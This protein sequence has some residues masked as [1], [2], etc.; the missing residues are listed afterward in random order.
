[1]IVPSPGVP[2]ATH[3]TTATFVVARSS[4]GSFQIGIRAPRFV[5]PNTAFI[6][7]SVN[8]TPTQTFPCPL[9]SVKSCTATFAVPAGKN[10]FS[11]VAQDAYG[12]ALS[13][14]AFAQDC[15]AGRNTTIRAV[16]NGVVAS[17]NL[18]VTKPYLPIGKP[19]TLKVLVAAYDASGAVIVGPGK[20]SLP[21]F[22]YDS[23]TTGATALSTKVVT[24]PS[25][26]VTLSYDGAGYVDPIITSFP[27]SVTFN[28]QPPR[29]KPLLPAVEVP[30][31]SG[32]LASN[33][34]A[35]GRDGAMW[36]SD[37]RGIGRAGATISEYPLPANQDGAG[38]VVRGSNGN[39]WFVA[40]NTQFSQG[41]PQGEVGQIDPSGKFTIYQIDAN[42][43][44]LNTVANGPDGNVWF[45]YINNSIGEIT[46]QGKVE[47]YTPTWRGLNLQAADLVTGSDG[48]LWIADGGLYLLWKYIPKTGSA[49]PYNLPY[50]FQPYRIVVGS[51]GNFYMNG[52]DGV[53]EA[54]AGGRTLTT[55]SFDSLPSYGQM[56]SAFGAIWV[57]LGLDADGHPEIGYIST[58]DGHFA[59]LALPAVAPFTN[60][61]AVPTAIALGP[62]NSLWYLR[63]HFVG[64][65]P[66]H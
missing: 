49:T 26:V 56:A 51:N 36:F 42:G 39:I 46:P 62:D 18:S 47:T 45:G 11:V 31:P 40:Y 21:I 34:L 5:S 43:Y 63:D 65:F 57:P 52:V 61:N 38:A 33:G 19:S 6:A 54:D 64:H 48:D 20:Y 22:L 55:Y 10:A 25:D 29:L 8:S 66:G 2:A 3:K 41:G 53:V 37:A 35:L 23:D 13:R 44:P 32:A 28:Y 58:I 9:S 7:I 60:Q 50:P 14:A 4:G 12:A 16:L 15:P 1:M 17:A 24:A 30:I 27:T 59:N